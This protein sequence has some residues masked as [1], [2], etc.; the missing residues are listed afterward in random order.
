MHV[1]ELFTAKEAMQRFGARKDHLSSLRRGRRARRA[2]W[3]AWHYPKR[4]LLREILVGGQSDSTELVP[5]VRLANTLLTQAIDAGAQTVD[6]VPGDAEMLVSFWESD[7]PAIRIPFRVATQVTA[8]M[9]DMAGLELDLTNQEQLGVIRLRH[10]D[11]NWI[12]QVTVTPTH[13]GE[14]V[15][16]DL[17]QKEEYGI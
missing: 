17:H 11:Q 5:V 3:F 16:L 6:L 1:E 8:R 4:E 7:A 14:R 15:Q 12:C 2:G 9:K 13:F 10:H